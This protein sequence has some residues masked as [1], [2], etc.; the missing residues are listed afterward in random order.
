MINQ[1]KEA[2]EILH[3]NDLYA[4]SLDSSNRLRGKS[5]SEH[6]LGLLGLLLIVSTL[7]ITLPSSG[8]NGVLQN[9]WP[10][11]VM[12]DWTLVQLISCLQECFHRYFSGPCGIIRNLSV[13]GPIATIS[14]SVHIHF[15]YAR[16]LS[17]RFNRIN[18]L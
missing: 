4:T 17:G 3:K 1:A 13:R 16:L 8:H 14:D 9:T 15:A 5:I 12:R 10:K 2:A 18:R 11:V 7:P 6:L